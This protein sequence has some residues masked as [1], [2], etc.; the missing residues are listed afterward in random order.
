MPSIPMNLAAIEACRTKFNELIAQHA[1]WFCSFDGDDA[2]ALRRSE[3]AVEVMH[4][5]LVLTAW[6]E[7]GTRAWKISA[8][9]WTGEKLLLQASRRMGAERPVIEL[10]PRASASA[11]ALTV[12]TARLQRAKQLGELTASLQ[13]NSKLERASLSPGA[14]RGQPGRY[15]RIVLRLKHERI[16]VT[17]SVASS[18]ARDADAFLA[19]ALIWFKRACE[20]TRSPYIQQ[21][22]LV[23]ESDLVKPVLQRVALLREALRQAIRVLVVDQQLSK[24]EIAEVPSRQDLWK[25]RLARFPPVPAAE[26]TVISREIHQAAADVVDVVSARHGETLRFYG[27][28]F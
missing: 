15:A 12:K 7:Q 4:G 27:L 11:I 3:L 5:R 24:L 19:G 22:W 14:R 17:G 13:P 18:T 25:R 8:W 21:L 28:P 1:E 2:F 26:L 9:D 16:A 20:R 6:T 23:V 10:L